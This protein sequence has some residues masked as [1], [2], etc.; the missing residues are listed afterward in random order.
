MVDSK[1][2]EKFDLR[3]KGLEIFMQLQKKSQDHSYLCFHVDP[4]CCVLY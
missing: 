1:N 4:I 3:V 2:N